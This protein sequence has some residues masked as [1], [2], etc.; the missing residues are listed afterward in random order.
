MVL[1]LSFACWDY[2]RTKA[3]E[4]GRVRP[5]GIELTYLNY[6]VEETFFRQLRFQEFDVSE[7]SLSSYVLT[8]SQ[9]PPPFI[10][11]PVFPSRFFRHQSMYINVN[12]GIQKPSDLK[13]KRIGIPEY[14]MTAA[15]WQ[16]GILEDE[17]GVHP[18]EVEFFTGAIEP[19]NTER[20]SKVPHTLPPGVKVVAIESG[21]NLSKMLEDGEIDAIFSAS[22]PSS[23]GRSSHCTYLFPDFKAVEAD[24]FERT[25]IFPIMH[26]IAIKRT[27]YEANPW[28]ARELQKG[29][30]K[31]KELAFE[32][33]VERAAL[34]YMLPWLEDHVR[35]T[36][37][38]MGED[39]WKDGF[40][41]NKHV[42]EKFL[43][44]SYSQGLAERQ[45]K[46]EELFAPGTL[47][48]FV[49]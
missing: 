23:V 30:A 46:A 20:K 47:E 19:S 8:L 3:L 43:S 6:R 5:E 45:Y 1:K 48:A 37:S 16:R 21:K 39:W 26:V 27:V 34:R 4:D 41:E 40:Y 13:G 15:V 28:I 17:F 9:E 42:I 29:F 49:I 11:I 44:Y 18:T 7:L 33:L 22:R 10:A 31:S 25:R 32:A 14:Q 36:Q 2:D 24:Y 12:S 38:I 35:E